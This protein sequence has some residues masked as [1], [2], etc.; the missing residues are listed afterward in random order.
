[1]VLISTVISLKC[2]I[3]S[4]LT[5][6]LILN[7]RID[8][9]FSGVFSPFTCFRGKKCL[10]S[11]NLSI[12]SSIYGKNRKNYAIFRAIFRHTYWVLR[13]FFFIFCYLYPSSWVLKR[14]NC[15]FKS[16]FSEKNEGTSRS[17]PW[18]K[19]VTDHI[20]PILGSHGVVYCCVSIW[21]KPQDG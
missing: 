14:K 3:L 21:C 10:F 11:R 18:K 17:I 12:C 8:L 9:F 5:W 4:F 1:M 6:V 2:I 20:P 16:I 13:W 19:T 7:S 15:A